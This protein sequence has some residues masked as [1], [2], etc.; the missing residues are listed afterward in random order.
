MSVR[1]ALF[2][3]GNSNISEIEILGKSVFCENYEE[4][5]YDNEQWHKVK[6]LIVSENIDTLVAFERQINVVS[7]LLWEC[8]N[9]EQYILVDTTEEM[10]IEKED[11]RRNKKL[12]D[13]LARSA[14]GGGQIAQ[15]GWKSSLTNDWF[16]EQEMAEYVDNTYCKLRPYCNST[17]KIIEVGIGSGLICQTIAPHV[18]QYIGIDI[19]DQTLKLTEEH[20]KMEGI[21]NVAMMRG[22]A[23][24]VNE[25]GIAGMD[26]VIINSV[27]QYFPGYNYFIRVVEN[28]LSC[29][30]DKAVIFVGDVLD[31]G[32]RELWK[33][34]MQKSGQKT[35]DK[36]LWYPRQFML[37]MPVYIK[38]IEK[39]EIS[40][41]KGNIKNELSMFRYD[42]LFL[43]DKK[44]KDIHEKTDRVKWHR[45]LRNL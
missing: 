24:H 4:I 36:D 29:L 35:N 1:N 43:I 34:A 26:I 8:Q 18:D 33:Q 14:C 12:W 6:A 41:K 23:L 31:L 42:V 2:F 25:F 27:A 22:D 13:V 37:Q 19:S 39:I 11:I 20:L 21:T 5:E 10:P 30:A 3:T 32:K 17:A 45:A 15:S 9:I 44:K 40:E 16:S 28:L 38:E 7:R